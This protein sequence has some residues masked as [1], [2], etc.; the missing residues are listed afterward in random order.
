[1]SSMEGN[2]TMRVVDQDMV[3]IPVEEYMNLIR[4]ADRMDMLTDD[5]R[6]KI[7]N[8]EPD[9][10]LVDADMVLL[11]T[12]LKALHRWKADEQK[13]AERATEAASKVIRNAILNP[14]EDDRK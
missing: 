8:N 1:M 10:A 11:M 14:E 5:I 3:C 13:A 12:G 6:D 9:Y 2:V 7:C 4:K